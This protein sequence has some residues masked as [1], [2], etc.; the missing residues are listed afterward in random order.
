MLTDEIIKAHP[1]IVN[2]TPLGTFPKTDEC[3]DL[4]YEAI[5]SSHFLFDLVYNPAVDEFLRRGNSAEPPSEIGYEMLV[6]Q[7]ELAWK[8]WNDTLTMPCNRATNN[9]SGLRV[10]GPFLIKETAPSL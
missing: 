6:G 2:C 1:L 3:P 7:A 8:I 5:G 9:P 4:P 10:Q